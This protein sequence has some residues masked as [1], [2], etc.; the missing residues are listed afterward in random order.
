MADLKGQVVPTHTVQAYLIQ[1]T[2]DGQQMALVLK[3]GAG[4]AAYAFSPADFARFAAKVLEV[5]ADNSSGPTSDDAVQTVSLPVGEVSF[6]SDPATPSVV[7][8]GSRIGRLRLALSLET[9]TFL[10]SVKQFLD[11]RVK[12][13][14]ARQ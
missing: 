12:A 1:P 13:G 8:V 11:D 2:D 10:R 14:A 9:N 5:A 6:E 3:V 4:T 7:R